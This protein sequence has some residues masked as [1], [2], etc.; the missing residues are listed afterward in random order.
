MWRLA[1][2]RRKIGKNNS[3]IRKDI[4]DQLARA[5]EEK[6]GASQGPGDYSVCQGCSSESTSDW[7]ACEGCRFNPADAGMDGGR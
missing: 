4:E 5:A 2:R 6:E 1:R 7:S 3:K